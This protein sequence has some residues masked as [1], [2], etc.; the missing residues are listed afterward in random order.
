MTV[1][2]C[3]FLNFLQPALVMSHS[4]ADRSCLA[5]RPLCHLLHGQPLQVPQ[6]QPAA[7]QPCVT[8][9]AFTAVIPLRLAMSS[10]N[11]PKQTH[12]CH[13]AALRRFC[14]DLL[15]GCMIYERSC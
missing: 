9:C 5:L 1:Q 3:L 14:N 2:P 11:T 7:R 13:T 8:S 12:Q 15:G 6:Q 4:A 10:L